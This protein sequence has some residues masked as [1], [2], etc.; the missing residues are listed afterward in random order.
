MVRAE[1]IVHGTV[2]RVGFRYAV[3]DAAMPLK[4][5]GHVKNLPDGTVEIVAEGSK[6]NIELLTQKIRDVREPAVVKDV[7]VSYS[8]ATGEFELFQVAYRD[9]TEALEEGFATGYALLM[10]SDKKQDQMLDKQDQMLDKQDQM[11][12]KQDQMLD[13]Q[14]QVLVV[15]GETVSAIRGLSDNMHDMIDGRFQ[16]LDGEIRL[17]KEKIGL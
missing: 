9:G 5:T 2:Q 7:R 16:R 10:N 14:D 4:V 17:I 1:I 12:D 6:E 3:L 15:Q 13:K 11:L 8:E